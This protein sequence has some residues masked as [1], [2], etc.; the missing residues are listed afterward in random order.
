MVCHSGE[1]SGLGHFSRTLSVARALAES[2]IFC[3]K[4][5]VA[6]SAFALDGLDEIELQEIPAHSD[7]FACLEQLIDAEE[8]KAFVF[9]LHP[10]SQ[11]PNL[12]GFISGLK[13]RKIRTIAI[14]S[15]LE[16][17][18]LLDLIWIPSCTFN[19]AEYSA[20]T[21]K[22]KSGWDSFLIRR[23]ERKGA[24]VPGDKILVL[25]GGSDPKKQCKSLPTLID[26][27]IE[28][29]KEVTWVRGPFAEFPNIPNKSRLNWRV[30]DSPSSLFSLCSEAN[31]AISVFGVTV[32][33]LLQ[34]GLPSVVFSPYG[35]KDSR[36]LSELNRQGVALT[37]EGP[38]LAVKKLSEL[39]QDVG[40]AEQLSRQSQR[41][42]A[43]NGL[44]EIVSEVRRLME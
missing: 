20:S 15:L 9:D 16:L 35:D 40:L 26:E 21:A 25:T 22:V 3:V 27:N 5:V 6:G 32:F 37:A 30:V 8:P 28:Q 12:R 42:L 2:D 43:K 1:A 29:G 13:T 19:E 34:F 23:W 24:W 18:D 7:L 14:D 41:K 38:E 39:L 17:R 31:Y 10:D 36:A 33:E 11:L 44:A 4:L